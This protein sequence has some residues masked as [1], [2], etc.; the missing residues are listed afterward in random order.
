MDRA[1]LQT[2][3]TKPQKAHQNKG[4]HAGPKN[5]G[6][7]DNNGNN[8]NHTSPITKIAK[9]LCRDPISVR[10]RPVKWWLVFRSAH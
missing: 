7:V 6:Q 10:I 4:I 1:L 5:S 8:D 9:Q 3:H 2:V